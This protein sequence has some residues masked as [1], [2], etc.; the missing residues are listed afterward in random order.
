MKKL[1]FIVFVLSVFFSNAQDTLLLSIEKLNS[2]TLEENLK[3]KSNNCEFQLSES[4]YKIQIGKALPTISLGVRQYTLEGLTQ[5]TEGD[6][7]DVN[8]NNEFRGVSMTAK[9]D[10]RNL[11][12]NIL[13]ADQYK[14][15]AFYSKESANI[16][17]KI[18]VSELFYDLIASQGSEIVI[19]KILDRNTEIVNQ[20]KLQ[21]SAGL[22]LKSDLL[23]SEANLNNLNIK[24]IDQKQITYQYN[25]QLLSI[26]NIKQDYII[27]VEFDFLVHL[28]SFYYT[29]IILEV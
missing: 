7:I 13:S 3:I 21:Y 8:K 12:F 19:Q 2:L 25:Q 23:L 1:I 27:N 29:Q 28:S 16:D 24:L 14:K 4:E 6:F 15:A 17:E 22:I 26:L 9:W 10:L 20:M 5:S 18:T 11:L